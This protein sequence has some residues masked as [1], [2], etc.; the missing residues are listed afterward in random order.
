M[1]GPA[2]RLGAVLVDE[3]VRCGVR[4][5]VLAPGSRNAPLALAL[6][7]ADRAGRLR[8]HVRVDERTAGFLALGL[9]KASGVPVPVACTSG[10][11]AAN[12]HPAVLEAGAA[13]VPLLVLTADR[14]PEL[15][16]AGANQTVDQV[17]LFGSALRWYAELGVPEGRGAPE[18]AYWRTVADR[19]FAAAVGALTRDPG[20]VHLNLPLREPLVGPA[21]GP[22]DPMLGRPDGGPWTRVDPLADLATPIEL[23]PARTLVVVGDAPAWLGARARLLAEASGWPLFAEPS[24]GAR[25]GPAAVSSY[26]LL[27][28]LPRV[29]AALAPERILVVGRPTISREVQA[30]LADPTVAVEVRTVSP[31]WPDPGRLATAVGWGLPASVPTGSSPDPSWLARWR[32]LD[33]LARAAIDAEI[34]R[35][36]ALGPLRLARDLVHAL[37]PGALLVAASSLA[38]R[39]LDVA[40]ADLSGVRVH[41]NRGA[42]GIDGTV[43]TAVGAALAAGGPAYALLGDLALLHDATGL[44]LGPDEPRP[45]LCLVV[46]DNDGGGIFAGLEM[47]R[48]EHAAGFE[49]VF[50]TP[51]GVDLA[52]WCAATGTAYR[53]VEHPGELADALRPV[54]GLRVVHVRTSRTELAERVERLRAAVEAAVAA[55]L[56]DADTFRNA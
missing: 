25:G 55:A 13:G 15:R 20:P 46:N 50:G 30:L 56:T 47:G 5:A 11:A 10:T 16:D 49:R 23:R 21:G 29:Q 31:R 48:P 51:H 43:S 35:D 52:A 2:G 36:G 42:A 34:D 19:A 26:P 17:K 24:S 18:A 38:V 1:S 4:E 14:P 12:L 40:A 27:L 8:L 9:A 54:R 45:D 3:L 33:R 22:V 39:D 6:D 41:A 7:A 37:P 53:R 28:R 32:E 44:V